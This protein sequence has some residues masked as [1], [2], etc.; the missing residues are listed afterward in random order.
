MLL[1][2]R[3]EYT[4]CVYVCIFMYACVY[5]CM[6]VCMYVCGPMSKGG[7]FYRIAERLVCKTGL[8]SLSSAKL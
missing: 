1:N 8:S 7:T 6:Y 5:V 4:V 3:D 2:V